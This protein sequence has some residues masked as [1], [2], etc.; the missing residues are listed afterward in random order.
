MKSTHEKEDQGRTNARSLHLSLPK[1]LLKKQF[2]IEQNNT[3]TSTSTNS[4][5]LAINSL[6]CKEEDLILL[7]LTTPLLSQRIM[8][9]PNPNWFKMPQ[10]DPYNG[11]SDMLDN[12]KGYKSLIMIQGTSNALLCIT[13]LAT[14][15][16][17]ARV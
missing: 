11:T 3:L 16:K 7:T 12:L 17:V 5:K 14:L 1:D 2:G 9:E 6:I 8:E 4:R 15:H 13:F 10:V